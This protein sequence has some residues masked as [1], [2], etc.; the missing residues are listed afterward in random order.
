MKIISFLLN[1]P[2]RKKQLIIALLDTIAIISCLLGAFLIRLGYWFFP[3]NDNDLLI[4]IVFSPILALPIF[5]YF[6]I[7]NDIN[8][9]M[10]FKSL[11]HIFQAV[12]MFAILWALT[13]FMLNIES[14]PRSVIFI[15]WLL[16]LIVISSS[17][18]FF[19]WILYERSTNINVLIYGAGSAGREL[20][21]VLKDSKEYNPVAYIDD[22]KN[23]HR[24][25]ING[26]KVHGLKDLQL[27]IN[28]KNIKEVLVA[29]PS[30]TRF[31]RNKIINYLQPYPVVVRS[32]P[33]IIDIASG[34]I[35]V[36][37]LLDINF[38]DLLGREPIEPKKIFSK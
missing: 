25:A 14:I 4:F 24:H 33:G 7:Y 27:L 10:G 17:R 8:R 6:G 28:N 3:S 2:R 31:Q 29:I 9:Y 35:T 22:D 21:N 20:S 1:L 34:K 11:W 18:L 32:L 26:L 38:R 16:V 13:T 23:I 15:N 12:S 5:A 30:L 37:D 36:N 19:R